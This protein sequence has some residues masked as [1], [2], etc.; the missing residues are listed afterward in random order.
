MELLFDSLRVENVEKVYVGL[1]EMVDY[2]ITVG[3]CV[4]TYYPMC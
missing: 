4:L 3:T 1:K 2:C